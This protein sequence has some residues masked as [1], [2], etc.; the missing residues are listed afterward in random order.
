MHA[1]A[2]A[3]RRCF[4]L[5]RELSVEDEYPVM[6]FDVTEAPGAMA[7]FMVVRLANFIISVDANACLVR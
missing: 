1:M 5:R 4:V 3:N 7:S 2:P 6:D